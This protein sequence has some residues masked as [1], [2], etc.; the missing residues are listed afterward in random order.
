MGALA[1][2][3]VVALAA[4]PAA[5]AEPIVAGQLYAMRCALCHGDS[6]RG[7]GMAAE[8]LEPRPTDF[9]RA[10][11]WRQRTPEQTREAIRNGKPGTAM[12]PFGTVLDGEEIDALAAYLRRFAAP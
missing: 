4:A 5:A 2:L 12:V 11:L 10:K 6:G 1:L 9:T 8:A 7:D 3:L